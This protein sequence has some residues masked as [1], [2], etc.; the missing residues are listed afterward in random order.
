MNFFVE[1]YLIIFILVFFSCV[2]SAE[3][4][5]IFDSQ[6][7]KSMSLQDLA[8]ELVNFDVI[9]F[10]EAHDDSIIHKLQ[11]DILPLLYV[12]TKN[13]AISME[14]FERD[15]QTV[16]DSFL[17]GKIAEKDFLEWGIIEN[18]QRE[19]LNPLEEAAAYQ[20]LIDEHG[21]QQEA[22]AKRV[23]KNRTTIANIVRL[24]RLPEGVREQVAT[25]RLA[26]G[27][28]RALLGLLTPE[29][30]RQMARKIVEEGLS[31][32]QVEAM[33]S[34]SNAQKRKPKK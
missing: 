33:V 12:H 23:G 2:I 5:K 22:V 17:E 8:N 25:G 7:G 31:V 14:M 6:T 9:F 15:T 1:I 28:A 3:E 30:Q 20:K 21:L 11:A 34:R 26:S 13:L 4:Y 27:H 29:H 10:G 16:V 32:R 19:D 18:I 24:L